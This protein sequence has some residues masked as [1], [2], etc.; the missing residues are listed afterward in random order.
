MVTIKFKNTEIKGYIMGYT[1][2]SNDFEIELEG[3]LKISISANSDVSY[4]I[5]TQMRISTNTLGLVTLRSSVLDFNKGVVEIL[6]ADKTQKIKT[7]NPINTTFV[8]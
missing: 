1:P 5:L 2:G 7:E 8:V 3:G 6:D 4:K